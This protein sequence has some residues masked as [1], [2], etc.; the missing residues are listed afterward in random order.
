[1]IRTALYPSA[2]LN[3]SRA[4]VDHSQAAVTAPIPPT[5]SSATALREIASEPI[6][7]KSIK[8]ER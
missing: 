6:C 7:R 3:Y 8:G 2:N 1:M 5:A 4:F